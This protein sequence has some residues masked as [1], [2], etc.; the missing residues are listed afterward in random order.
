MDILKPL[1]A[2]L[3][4]RRATLSLLQIGGHRQAGLVK[5][6]LHLSFDDR[7]ALSAPLLRRSEYMDRCGDD[8][9]F[10]QLTQKIDWENGWPEVP[11]SLE[12]E[13][14]DMRRLRGAAW[15]L[16]SFLATLKPAAVF[17]PEDGG[18]LSMMAVAKCR[19]LGLP[20]ITIGE[21]PLQGW[22]TLKRNGAYPGP[23]AR[24]LTV[25]EGGQARAFLEEIRLQ[26]GPR[27][28]SFKRR[29]G[30]AR[31]KT[32][33]VAWEN[34]F[35][36]KLRAFRD[37]F[38]GRLVYCPGFSGRDAE[39]FAAYR[40][41]GWQSPAEAARHL[42]SFWPEDVG[43]LL[44]DA[45]GS[46]NGLSLPP[47]D[48]VF[49]LKE[50]DEERALEIASVVAAFSSEQTLQAALR[51]R[52][53]LNLASSVCSGLDFS[54]DWDWQS[55]LE[56]QL[57]ELLPLKV[58]DGAL[59]DFL[60]QL[61][62]AAWIDLNGSGG[63]LVEFLERIETDPEKLD[64]QAHFWSP[65][66]GPFADYHR[67]R[68][69]Y[70][71][72][73]YKNISYREI[74][75]E[76]G[77]KPQKSPALDTTAA[78]WREAA[79]SYDLPDPAFMA[80]YAWA[81]HLLPEGGLALD[82][83]CGDGHGTDF[84]SL[85]E[86]VRVLALD[87]RPELLKV[88]RAMCPSAN[89]D[90]RLSSAGGLFRA[91]LG[92]DYALR[93]D[94]I[95][96]FDLW[97]RLA[98]PALFRDKALSLL[99]ERGVL[100][101]ALP[102][103]LLAED[104][105]ADFLVDGSENA[106]RPFYQCNGEIV[107][108]DDQGAETVIFAFSRRPESLAALEEVVPFSYVPAANSPVLFMPPAIFHQPDDPP[109]PEREY[110][111]AVCHAQSEKVIF[112]G[113]YR[114]LAAGEWEAAFIFEADP[115]GPPPAEELPRVR[116]DIVSGGDQVKYF[117]RKFTLAELLSRPQ[118]RLRLSVE[119][120]HFEFRAYHVDWRGLIDDSKEPPTV[121]FKGIRLTRL[122]GADE[123]ARLV[124]PTDRLIEDQ[125]ALTAAQNALAATQNDLVTTKNALASAQNNFVAAQSRMAAA[126]E[127]LKAMYQSLSWRLT[128]PLRL[129]VGLWRNEF[130]GSLGEA[131][132]EVTRRQPQK[133]YEEPVPQAP[134]QPES[135]RPAYGWS[136]RVLAIA[137]DLNQARAARK[138]GSD[139]SGH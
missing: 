42:L 106:S 47:R 73:A 94:L 9:D 28:P 20:L 103:N 92:E 8:L 132:K 53:I 139:A 64:S 134:A 34:R 109:N 18:P 86:G 30:P 74:M 41:R 54:R 17:L 1:Q 68:K 70:E 125:L 104:F 136:P 33:A 137:E 69:D 16:E 133:M 39:T 76:L 58:E 79:G 2:I 49:L 105:W 78:R 21:G 5:E 131:L 84:L 128:A 107:A 25:A 117:D 96:A 57:N 115:A 46:E 71:R 100:L 122:P 77:R 91:G 6:G 119:T 12:P 50:G 66:R 51:G 123:V 101:G 40:A 90:Y 93:F 65:G 19:K 4:R 108:D 52:P 56:D 80:R 10:A 129:I 95:V 124:A 24:K 7:G 48:Q 120:G 102:A 126:E 31:S 44:K 29:P 75:D 121:R 127:R 111:T 27:V 130:P 14:P 37:R 88:A 81:A 99:S 59:A 22:A 113:P 61:K 82:A 118:A 72:L 35:D 83:S 97:P 110:I 55:E 43:L 11:E 13:R 98:D 63:D 38:A 87:D 32:T 62:R 112:Y 23:W 3:E 67:L 45:G 89:V 60:F 138:G 135:V 15:R 114:P 85:K 116:L 26:G 36:P